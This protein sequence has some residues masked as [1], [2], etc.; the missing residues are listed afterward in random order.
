MVL[1]EVRCCILFLGDSE[2]AIG[3]NYY[4]I[5]SRKYLHV[6]YMLCDRKKIPSKYV[7]V[8][9]KRFLHVIDVPRKIFMYLTKDVVM[10]SICYEKINEFTKYALMKSMCYEIKR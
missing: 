4:M 9:H 6:V 10:E 7:Y 2:N 1:R 3:Q 8:L 5:N